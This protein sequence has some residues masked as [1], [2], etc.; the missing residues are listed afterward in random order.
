MNVVIMIKPASAINL[1]TSATRRMFFGLMI[2]RKSKVRVQTVAN[3]IAIQNVDVHLAIEQ[4]AF[5]GLSQSRFS[6]PG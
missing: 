2:R 4:V 3:I 1:A 5:E 6:G